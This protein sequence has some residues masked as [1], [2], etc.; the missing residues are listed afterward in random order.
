MGKDRGFKSL[1]E[2]VDAQPRTMT[3]GDIARALGLTESA[4]S[5]YLS[6]KRFPSRQTA[7]ELSKR[8]GI[9]FTSLMGLEEARTA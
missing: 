1:R 8:T 4:L 5:L 3:Q 6:R 9:P 2:Y 7:I